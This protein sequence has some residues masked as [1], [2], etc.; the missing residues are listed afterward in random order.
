MFSL[1]FT[2]LLIQL[3]IIAINNQSIN[4]LHLVAL[5]LIIIYFYFNYNSKVAMYALKLFF[6]LF[7]AELFWQQEFNL[8]SE[9][10]IILIL[11][12]YIIFIIE[13]RKGSEI[14]NL[15]ALDLLIILIAIGGISIDFIIGGQ[16]IWFFLMIITIWFSSNFIFRRT[17]FIRN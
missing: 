8:L 15:S 4:S 9:I 13:K 14:K 1:F 2:F 12:S 17:I 6:I 10:L 16:S 5:G 3:F 11:V 7:F